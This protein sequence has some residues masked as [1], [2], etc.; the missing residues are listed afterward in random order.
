MKACSKDLLDRAV[1][2]IVKRVEA[3]MATCRPL[4]S[5]I[6]AA[7]THAAQLLQDVP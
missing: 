7:R 3:L 4:E 2:V 5:E 1:A 6:A